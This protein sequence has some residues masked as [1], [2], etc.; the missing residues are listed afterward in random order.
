MKKI[1][2]MLTV[3]FF[4][5]GGVSTMNAGT[6]SSQK[7]LDHAAKLKIIDAVSNAYNTVYVFPDVAEKMEKRLRKNL[8]KG[9][10]DPIS[11][12]PEFTMAITRDLQDVSHDKHI[13]VHV[14]D[15][16]MK[17]ML[18]TTDE[19]Q[20]LV[21]PEEEMKRDNYM[22]KKLEILDGNIG[23]IRLDMFVDAA[24]AGDTAVAAMGFLANC[25]ALIFDL[26][27]NG[28][29][30]PSMIQLL[31]SY[32]VKEPTHLNSFYVRK[33]DSTQQFWTQARVPGPSLAHVPVYVL[34]SSFTFSGAEEFT[35]NLKSLKRAVII[36]ETTGGGAHPVESHPFPELDVLAI[37]PYGRAVNPITGTNW[38]G[39][40]V[41]PD[42]QV[43]AN[44]ALDRA[45]I[46]ALKKLVQSTKDPITKIKMEWALTRMNAKLNPPK[47]DPNVLESYSGTYGDRQIKM[48]NGN[49]LYRRMQRPWSKLQPV[50]DT[51]FLVQGFDD[52]R[53]EVFIDDNGH[54]VKLI[55][56]YA[57]GRSDES[58]RNTK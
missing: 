22:F 50:T 51:M 17:K 37:V 5:L 20:N 53:L 28:G 44:Q 4:V 26:R 27:Y 34:T 39:S 48:E 33:T 29:G 12:L 36:G 45:H 2:W 57:D 46:E 38:E 25:D 40:G 47:I 18:A 52:F 42:I 35:Y 31:T 30:N 19:P 58:I 11:T 54:P 21:F 55:G 43:P 3:T 9:M 13:S 41:T 49:L 8:K 14:L 16:G 32:L 1:Y 56:H 15:P 6:D 24:F 10:Y 23:Y 7:P